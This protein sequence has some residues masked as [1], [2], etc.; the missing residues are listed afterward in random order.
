MQI[1]VKTGVGLDPRSLLFMRADNLLF[2]RIT[3]GQ[4][5]LFEVGANQTVADVKELVQAREGKHHAYVV[6]G[7]FVTPVAMPY[8]S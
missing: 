1:F 8:G 7:S 4:T 6:S 2:A 5:H 3:A